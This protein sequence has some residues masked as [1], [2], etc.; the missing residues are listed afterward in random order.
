MAKAVTAMIGISLEPDHE[1][2]FS[3]KGSDVA[4]IALCCEF[5]PTYPKFDLCHRN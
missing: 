5:G 2:M 3:R 1:W 4:A